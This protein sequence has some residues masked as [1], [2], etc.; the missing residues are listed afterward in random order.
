MRFTSRRNILE[1]TLIGWAF[2]NGEHVSQ[3][4]VRDSL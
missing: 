1:T 2:L 3:L 4:L